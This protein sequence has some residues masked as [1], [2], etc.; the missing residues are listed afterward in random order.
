MLGAIDCPL[1]R[2]TTKDT[3][4]A[5]DGMDVTQQVQQFVSVKDVIKMKDPTACVVVRFVVLKSERATGDRLGMA[6][7]CRVLLGNCTCR[8]G[9]VFYALAKHRQQLH[10]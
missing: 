2:I 1:A 5:D 4:Q 6:L 7:V 8:V 3:F 9:R 10:A